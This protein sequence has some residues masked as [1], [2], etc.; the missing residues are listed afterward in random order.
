MKIITHAFG[1]LMFVLSLIAN[2][3]KVAVKDCK[4]VKLD[5]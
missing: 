3:L 2:G 4:N 5:K 1:V